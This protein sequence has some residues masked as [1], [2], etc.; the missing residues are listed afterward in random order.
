[1]PGIPI[2]MG[3]IA[4]RVSWVAQVVVAVILLQTLFFKLQGAPESVWIFSQLGVEPWGRWLAAGVELVAGVGLLVPRAAALAAV[5]A[6]SVGLGAVATHL[7]VLGVEVQGDE[8]LLFALALVVT[9]GAGL[10]AWL[11]RAQLPLG[12][13]VAKNGY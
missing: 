8:G 12:A 10:V 1:M 5:L 11:R 9:S 7:V 6:L 13:V 2:C 4:R 3:T